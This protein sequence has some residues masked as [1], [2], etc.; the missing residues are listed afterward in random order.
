MN[1]NKYLLISI[2]VLLFATALTPLI[3]TRSTGFPYIFG[4]LV[5]LRSIVEIALI[6]CLFYLLLNY[7][8]LQLNYN[9][10]P[11][12]YH[13]ITVLF[14]NPL[15]ISVVLFIFSLIISTIFAVDNYRA[16]WGTISRGE[17]LFGM[18]HCFVIFLLTLLF[19]RKKDWLNLLKIYLVGG[20]ILAFYAFLQRFKFYHFPFAL[21]YEDPRP[22]SFLG[23][24]SFLATHMIFIIFFAL[25]I[26]YQHRSAQIGINQRLNKFWRYFSLLT[27]VSSAA[28]IFLTS[29]RGAILGLAA[30][31][32][33]LLVYF[34]FAKTLMTADKAPINADNKLIT[35]DKLSAVISQKISVNQ[36][37][38]STVLLILIIIFGIVFTTTR[39]L[40]I[41]QKIPG[42]NR[43]AQTSFMN[44]NDPSTQTRLITWKLSWEAFKEKPFFGWGP[45]NYLIAYEKYYDP[46]FAIYG[47][48]WLDRAHNKIFDLL[49]MQ[50]IFGFL[51][52][53]GIFIAAFYC[54][55]KKQPNY[56]AKPLIT[57]ELRGEAANYAKPFIAALLISYF[58]Q[59]LVLFDQ[60]NSN[61]AFFVIL[62]YLI[63]TELRPDE[64]GQITRRSR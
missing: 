46:D 9:K 30:G 63:S 1:L 35:A 4:K 21:S 50:G 2:K 5:F 52:Y 57:T 45:D 26:F 28:T 58:V 59:N 54:L 12:N 48:T 49:V 19:F 37:S 16:F 33:V 42:F 64:I 40:E 10:L 18:L 3:V 38:I 24:S 47:E 14:K 51:T 17:G 6:L 15:F 27:I 31:I 11:L 23:N 53:L 43:L 13:L 36:R 32:F 56:A 39:Q 7:H 22:G 8:K 61:I 20:F 60:L 62:G 41:W 29:T 55:F 44:V 25:I 34:A